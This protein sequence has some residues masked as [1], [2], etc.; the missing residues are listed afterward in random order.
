MSE[1]IEGQLVRWD[2]AREPMPVYEELVDDLAERLTVRAHECEA[3]AYATNDG[4][5]D[6]ELGRAQAFHEAARMA[7][8]P[9]QSGSKGEA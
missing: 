5:R 2:P 9:A 3:A 6:T 1:R 4:P 7:R 8:D